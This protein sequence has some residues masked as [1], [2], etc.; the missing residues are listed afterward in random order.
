MLRNGIPAGPLTVS[1]PG[2]TDTLMTIMVLDCLTLYTCRPMITMRRNRLN[3]KF[4]SWNLRNKLSSCILASYLHHFY[5]RAWKIRLVRHSE[6]AFQ[7]QHN[8]LRW[9]FALILESFIIIPILSEKN[10]LLDFMIIATVYLLWHIVDFVSVSDF[11]QFD[12][13]IQ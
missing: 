10:D 7:V 5:R 3:V 2:H 11:Y 13:K 4:R 9:N 6:F 8:I 1:T 12:S